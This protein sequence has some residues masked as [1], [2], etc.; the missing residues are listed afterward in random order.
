MING[1]L[2]ASIRL[3]FR[4]ESEQVSIF[5][6]GDAADTDGR[7]LAPGFFSFAPPDCDRG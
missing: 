1:K 6:R 3:V 7:R 2:L 4:R 5:S